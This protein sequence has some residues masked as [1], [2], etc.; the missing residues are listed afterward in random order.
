LPFGGNFGVGVGQASGPRPAPSGEVTKALPS[1]HAT[2]W[3]GPAQ[4]QV[5]TEAGRCLLHTFYLPITRTK[6]LETADNYLCP[7]KTSL[8]HLTFQLCKSYWVRLDL[9]IPRSQEELQI[10]IQGQ[11]LALCLFSEAHC[12]VSER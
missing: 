11:V 3:W 4:P 1:W 7:P 9:Q 8:A 2:A 10:F 12:V 6:Q 5:G